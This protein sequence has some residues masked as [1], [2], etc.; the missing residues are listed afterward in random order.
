VQDQLLTACHALKTIPNDLEALMFAIYAAS[1]NTL[2]DGECQSILGEPKEPML[3]KF[4][5]GNQQALILAGLLRSSSLI[6]LQAFVLSLV[7][8]PHRWIQSF[9]NSSSISPCKIGMAHEQWS[10]LSG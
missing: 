2:T 5:S 4:I 10:F 6:V 1:V 3:L 9:V 7:S 8:I